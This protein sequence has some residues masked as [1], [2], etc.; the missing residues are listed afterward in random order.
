MSQ[1]NV[2]FIQGNGAFRLL[3]P[4]C[5]APFF[6]FCSSI[7]CVTLYSVSLPLRGGRKS[8]DILGFSLLLIINQQEMSQK[9]L[10][11][12][13]WEREREIKPLQNLMP[14]SPKQRNN[15]ICFVYIPMRMVTPHRLSLF[16]ISIDF[17]SVSNLPLTP[18]PASKHQP[19]WSPRTVKL[20]IVLPTSSSTSA[21][22]WGFKA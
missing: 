19:D 14:F 20:K 17:Y 1:R 6:T 21:A 12:S 9:S 13:H 22:F 2:Y 7:L 18:S 4:F 11:C 8:F 15:G 3:L 16:R 5:S 10:F